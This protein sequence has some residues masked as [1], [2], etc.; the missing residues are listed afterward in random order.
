MSKCHECGCEP[1][2]NIYGRR[3][4]QFAGKYWC[5]TCIKHRCRFTLENTMGRNERFLRLLNRASR[6]RIVPPQEINELVSRFSSK[7]CPRRPSSLS[8]AI[9]Y[10][11][12]F[13]GLSS[14]WYKGKSLAPTAFEH[15]MDNPVELFWE[16]LDKLKQ[17]HPKSAK[18]RGERPLI[19]LL[20]AITGDKYAINHC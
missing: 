16:R 3:G 11:Y 9:H 18:L 5:G 14:G 8:K 15:M 4:E 7:V 6:D 13:K 20:L 12:E 19:G 2:Y 1:Y 10:G 17:E